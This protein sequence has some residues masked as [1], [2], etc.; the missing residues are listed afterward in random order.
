MVQKSLGLPFSL[1]C[2]KWWDFKSWRD[3]F[4]HSQNQ[5]VLEEK[6]FYLLP[7]GLLPHPI[8][9]KRVLGKI[10]WWRICWW[11][12]AI[13]H[14]DGNVV[15]KKQF[16]TTSFICYEHGQYRDIWILSFK[17]LRRFQHNKLGFQ[18]SSKSLDMNS[19]CTN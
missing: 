7:T 1:F 19:F 3:Y 2:M 17:Y 5:N 11:S 12:K 16:T 4:L 8:F 9:S 6:V 15:P 14:L 13:G 10:Y 18:F